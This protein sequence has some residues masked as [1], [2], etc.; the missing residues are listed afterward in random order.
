[1]VLFEG[2]YA[3]TEPT[4]TPWE[5]QRMM[6]LGITLANV[7]EVPREGSFADSPTAQHFEMFHDAGF[8]HVRIPVSFGRHMMA[9]EPYTID[10]ALLDR[11]AELATMALEHGLVVVI[12]ATNE[13]WIDL[14]EKTYVAGQDWKFVLLPRFESLWKQVGVRFRHFRQH[15]IFGLLN[16][17]HNLKVESLNELHRLALVAVRESNPT[18]VVTLSGKD[19]GNPRWCLEY[20]K[21]LFIPRDPQL[22]LEIHVTEPHGFAGTRPSRAEWGADKELFQ[23]TRDMCQ[24]LGV[25]DRVAWEIHERQL[26]R[27]E[28]ESFGVLQDRNGRP[29]DDIDEVKPALFPLTAILRQ[30]DQDIAKV[31]DWVNKIEVYGRARNLPVY[32]GEFGC[33]NQVTNEQGRMLWIETNW[34]EMRRKG[35]C[36]SLMDDGDQFKVYDRA[37]GEWDHE[38]LTILQRSLPGL[39]GVS[40]YRVGGGL[41]ADSNDPTVDLQRRL[42]LC[43]SRLSIAMED[44]QKLE[45]LGEHQYRNDLH[46]GR[47]NYDEDDDDYY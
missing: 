32:V 7:L 21:A 1:M 30:K 13:W 12:T 15:L 47:G 19:F 43:F 34:R 45:P 16:E 39:Q 40:M 17:P 24:E 26:N 41:G 8:A 22:M 38:V 11:A 33:S 23:L 10:P 9:D 36:A 31:R 28:F 37:S 6:G 44:V 4:L 27:E 29:I 46:G 3:R 2:A 25:R 18:R 35:F 42:E 14:E 20:P 5:I